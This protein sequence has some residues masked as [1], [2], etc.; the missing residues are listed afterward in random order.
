[1]A[2]EPQAKGPSHAL[3]PPPR[4]GMQVRATDPPRGRGRRGLLLQVCEGIAVMWAA[5]YEKPS[6][7]K[8]KALVTL[9]PLRGQR[10]HHLCCFG[11]KR[12][13]RQD[14][15]CVHTDAVMARL[16]EQ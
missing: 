4:Q 13:Y 7:G 11:N 1:M 6:H 14:G 5:P 9:I 12:H 16:T 2:T 3:R 15:S 10:W 8:T